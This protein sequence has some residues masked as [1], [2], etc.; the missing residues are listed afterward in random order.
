MTFDL[1]AYHQYLAQPRRIVEPVS[2]VGHI[3]FA[4]LLVEV[5]RPSVV[6]E[7]GVH[8]GNSF[9][10]FCQAVDELELPATCYGVDTWRGDAHAG[11]YD[12]AV[13]AELSAYQGRHYGRFAQLMRMTFDEAR[14]YFAEGTVDL[15]HIDGL[16]TYEAVQHDFEHW[17][18][19]LSPRGVV[20]FHDTRVR[21]RDFGVWRLWSELGERY[22]SFD[23]RHSHGLGVLL[24]GAEVPE[25]VR[26]LVSALNGGGS[27]A[28]LL[29]QLGEA[30]VAEY[31]R[32]RLVG[33]LQARVAS[34]QT[35]V[36]A[37]E[38]EKQA[39]VAK[40]HERNREYGRLCRDHAAVSQ[41]LREAIEHR[42]YLA[43][44]LD[45]LRPA[46]ED[47]KK[48]TEGLRRALKGLEARLAERERQLDEIFSSTLWKVTA[49]LRWKGASGEGGS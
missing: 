40:L 4:F 44:R 41:S 47:S 35:Q 15:L 33:E 31:H 22:P 34:L 30:L 23:F 7:L 38:R 2:W 6:V 13:Y 27:L 45:E 12:D 29:A 42:Q 37:K 25:K 1:T 39:L 36:A 21:E 32:Q 10:A 14:S 11:S 28:A 5:L 24:V 18:D 43:G 8:T 17:R 16:H 49:P 19:R 3:P 20:L 9:N 48:E 26:D 46:L